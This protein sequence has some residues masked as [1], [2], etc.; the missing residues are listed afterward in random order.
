M[1]KKVAVTVFVDP[2]IEN[3]IT[4]KPF[5]AGLAEPAPLG[6]VHTEGLTGTATGTNL[7]GAAD[8]DADADYNG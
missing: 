1:A 6:A 5:A 2:E 3:T 8:I 7:Q 4:I